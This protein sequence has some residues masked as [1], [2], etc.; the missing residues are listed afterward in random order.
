MDKIKTGAS[1]SRRRFLGASGTMLASG[2]ALAL[3]GAPSA[4][5]AAAPAAPATMTDV[6]ALNYALTLEH[7]E[8]AF[9]REGQSRFSRNDFSSAPSLNAVG[10][11]VANQAYDR[12]NE[13]A[14][15]ERQHVVTLMSVIHS[16]GGE[17]VAAATYNF[18]YTDLVGYIKTAMALENT[19]VMAYDGAVAAIQAAQLQTAAA[20]IATVEARH[21]AYLNLLNGI[22][23]FPNAF[24]TPK[25]MAEILAIA[26]PFI[27]ANGPAVAPSPST[28]QSSYTVVAGDNYY[29]IA[30]RFGITVDAL[31]QANNIPADQRNF[32]QIGTV[33]IIPKH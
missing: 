25:T 6:D 14:D 26:G 10:N 21:A 11:W 19:G 30:R 22:S 7:L 13:I 9:Y 31:Y 20:T 28:G 4:A 29:S 1:I 18:G 17:P 33:L 8:A 16:L 27:V 24:D 3:S 32:L 23:P 15:H 12:F 2:V 5:F